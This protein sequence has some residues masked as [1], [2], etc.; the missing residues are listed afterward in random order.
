MMEYYADMKKNLCY[1]HKG[2]LPYIKW[3]KKNRL[4]YSMNSFKT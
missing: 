4:Q 1:G 3:K 2:G